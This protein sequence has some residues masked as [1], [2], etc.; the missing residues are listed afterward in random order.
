MTPSNSYIVRTPDERA[1]GQEGKLEQDKL[2]QSEH[3]AARGCEGKVD[4]ASLG[5]VTIKVR[6]DSHLSRPKERDRSMDVREAVKQAKSWI[7]DVMA[8]ERPEHIGLEEVEF[9]DTARVWKITLGF[10]RPWNSTKSAL[11]TLTGEI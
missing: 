3:Y 10:S 1:L 4:I 7:Q 8:D 5:Q 9:D 2:L 11:S 6:N